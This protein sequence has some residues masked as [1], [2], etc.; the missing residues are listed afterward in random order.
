MEFVLSDNDAFIPLWTK[1]V[2]ENSNATWAYLPKRL[3]FYRH[4]SRNYRIKDLSFIIIQD[5]QPLCIYPLF[6]ERYDNQNFFTYS[7]N[8]VRTPL[9]SQNLSRNYSEKVQKICFEEIDKWAHENRVVQ[10]KMMIDNISQEYSY[11]FLT[12][13]DFLNTSINTSILNLS[14]NF[15]TIWKNL[16]KSYKSLINNGKKY[17]DIHIMDHINVNKK[18]FNTH[19]ELHYKAAGKVTR[20]EKT[21][22]LQYEML[23]DDNAILIGL[24]DKDQFIAFSYLAHNNEM[25]YYGNSS[26]D[27]EYNAT[28][29]LEH[30]I[31]WTAI[32]YYKNRKFKTLEFGHQYFGKQ[33]FRQP[34]KKDMN[35]SFFKRGFGGKIVTLYRGVKYYNKEFMKKDLTRNINEMLKNISI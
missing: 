32:E 35:I 6:L 17:Y 7:R 20:P 5:K 27:P 31:I 26:D 24:K 19:R 15:D 11:N 13:Y 1:F 3:E 29:P 8:Y 25:T 9:F 18:I 4:Y 12:K 10:I 14:E 23:K 22:D 30:T 2:K 21:W 16:R 34:S 28:I 33:L